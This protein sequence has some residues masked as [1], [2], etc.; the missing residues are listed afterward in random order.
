[1]Q[2]MNQEVLLGSMSVEG[3]GERKGRDG[4]GSGGK[5]REGA[6]VGKGEFGDAGTMKA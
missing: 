2:E 6:R 3:K 4:K 1:M 5:E